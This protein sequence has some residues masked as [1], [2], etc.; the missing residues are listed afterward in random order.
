MEMWQY[1]CKNF[2]SIFKG[3]EPED[4]RAY[5]AF[6]LLERCMESL[7]IGTTLYHVNDETDTFPNA[8][9]P[10]SR[11]LEG[12]LYYRQMQNKDSPDEI[13]K[14]TIA[15]DNVKGITIVSG[16]HLDKQEEVLLERR[17]NL[18]FDHKERVHIKVEGKSVCLLH[19][20][21]SKS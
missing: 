19:Y 4:Q 16:R 15:S 11:S 14:Y 8:W 12:L 2:V 1:S 13:C 21:V 7:L 5:E 9:V 10:A 3:E 17:S 6:N 18:T 20:N